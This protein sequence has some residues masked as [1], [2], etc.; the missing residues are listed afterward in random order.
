M[1]N[2]ANVQYLD[3]NVIST[4][5][6]VNFGTLELVNGLEKEQAI[7]MVQNISAGFWVCRIDLKDFCS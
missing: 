5:K 6:F 4:S 3:L 2:L 7:P 1:E